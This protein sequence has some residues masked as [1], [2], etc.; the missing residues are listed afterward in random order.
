MD[1]DFDLHYVLCLYKTLVIHIINVKHIGASLHKAAVF[2]GGHKLIKKDLLVSLMCSSVF[3]VVLV[4]MYLVVPY[5]EDIC[6]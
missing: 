4:I 6:I 5:F 1:L 2:V 3:G